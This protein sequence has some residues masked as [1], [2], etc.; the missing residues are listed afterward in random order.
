[1][2]FVYTH[3]ARG[4]CILSLCSSGCVC[5]HRGG[6]YTVNEV[7]AVCVSTVVAVMPVLSGCLC[8]RANSGCIQSM[9]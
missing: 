7:V 8:H 2:L 3:P 4:C 5:E 6:C 9:K 1:M